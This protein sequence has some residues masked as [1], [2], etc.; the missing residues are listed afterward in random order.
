MRLSRTAICHSPDTEK[1]FKSNKHPWLLQSP[2]TLFICTYVLPASYFSSSGLSE[3]KSCHKTKSLV[4]PIKRILEKQK[5]N[6]IFMTWVFQVFPQCPYPGAWPQRLL[7]QLQWNEQGGLPFE[8]A[9][10]GM[11]WYCRNR[12]FISEHSKTA[13]YTVTNSKSQTIRKHSL[14]QMGFVKGLS[15]R[16]ICFK[17]HSFPE[18]LLIKHYSFILC[19][20]VL[21]INCG[22]VANI[23][24]LKC[25]VLVIPS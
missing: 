18:A 14:V 9:Q 11:T 24:G 6:A 22:W 25:N 15:K 8:A 3:T 17:M 12:V 21:K 7:L 13:V 23:A 19:N 16:F 10:S 4:L 2:Q 1:A 20:K 5:E